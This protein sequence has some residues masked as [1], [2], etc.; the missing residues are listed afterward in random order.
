VAV[1][2]VAVVRLTNDKRCSIH[3]M[4]VEKH[5]RGSERITKIFWNKW[6]HL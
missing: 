1:V 3:N 2:V 4:R 5:C 6:A